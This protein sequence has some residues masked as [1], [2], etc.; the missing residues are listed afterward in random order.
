VTLLGCFAIRA[1]DVVDAAINEYR[2]AVEAAKEKLV[3]SLKESLKSASAKGENQLAQKALDKL[4]EYGGGPIPKTPKD[5]TKDTKKDVVL[6]TKQIIIGGMKYERGLVAR[7]YQNRLATE[8]LKM[9]D[10]FVFDGAW[11]PFKIKIQ[12]KYR[13][14]LTTLSPRMRAKGFIISKDDDELTF[15]LLNAYVAIDGKQVTDSEWEHPVMFKHKVSRG[16]HEIITHHNNFDSDQ[17]S[18]SITDKNGNSVLYYLTPN[19]QKELGITG[20]L[21]GKSS[22]SELTK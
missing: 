20:K 18:L 3:I 13:G 15:K 8:A 5:D 19:L 4:K 10:I 2:I 11:D 1:E 9:P 22:P 7:V 21:D 6:D 14:Q 17:F 16:I 12:E